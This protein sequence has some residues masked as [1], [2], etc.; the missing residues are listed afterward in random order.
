[1]FVLFFFIFWSRAFDVFR[2]VRHCT[3]RTT[4][5]F[6]REPC[7][8]AI[9]V[10]YTWTR[11]RRCPQKACAARERFW[12]SFRPGEFE[13]STPSAVAPFSHVPR[14]SPVVRLGSPNRARTICVKRNIF[15]E[16]LTTCACLCD[17]DLNGF[18]VVHGPPIFH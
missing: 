5:L 12:R 16:T 11:F 6:A 1:M 8:F 14:P 18:T 3:A 10:K 4:L 15:A 2:S 9:A 7:V 17:P 13:F